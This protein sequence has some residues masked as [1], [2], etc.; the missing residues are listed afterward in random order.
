LAAE[1]QLPQPKVIDVAEVQADK[2]AI[3]KLFKQNAKLIT[4]YLSKLSNQEV[5]EF[6]ARL[7]SAQK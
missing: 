1:K 4:E 6:E 5:D 3:G 2:G 7:K